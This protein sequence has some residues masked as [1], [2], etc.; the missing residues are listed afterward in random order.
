MPISGVSLGGAAN[1]PS[2]PANVRVLTLNASTSPTPGNVILGTANTQTLP[3][4]KV[5]KTPDF[6]ID[7]QKFIQNLKEKF[8]QIENIPSFPRNLLVKLDVGL[9]FGV[10]VLPEQIFSKLVDDNN[11][12]LKISPPEFLLQHRVLMDRL[13]AEPAFE[14]VI[15]GL[16][17]NRTA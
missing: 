17:I 7:L 5:I 3:L 8:R 11:Q 10:F 4:Q 16:I 2:L 1:G 14:R 12:T 15:A 6:D 13:I 9:E